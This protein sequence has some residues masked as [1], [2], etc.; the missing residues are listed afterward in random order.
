MARMYHIL[1]VELY[2]LC[3]QRVSDKAKLGK[4][5]NNL[6]HG[7]ESY[8]HHEKDVKAYTALPLLLS[9][10]LTFCIIIIIL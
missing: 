10:N 9:N 2:S 7:G 5:Q 3:S 1:E 6:K 8:L 4:G